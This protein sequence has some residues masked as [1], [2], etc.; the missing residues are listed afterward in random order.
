MSRSFVRWVH[1]EHAQGTSVQAE[2]SW[3]PSGPLLIRG[4]KR[5]LLAAT[6]QK[7]ADGT[8]LLLGRNRPRL[9][10]STN[11]L[12]TSSTA[13][14]EEPFPEPTWTDSGPQPDMLSHYLGCSSAQRDLPGDT[15]RRLGGDWGSRGRRFKSGRPDAGQKADSKSR[16]SLLAHWG[17]RSQPQAC[18]GSS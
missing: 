3:R 15:Q 4:F 17:P 1:S 8:G 10:A 14:Q 6:Y 11:S 9:R 13:R 5:D 12:G 7:D 18:S 2:R 16:I